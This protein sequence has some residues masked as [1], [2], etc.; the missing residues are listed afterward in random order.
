[1]WSAIIQTS[2]WLWTDWIVNQSTWTLARESAPPAGELI[3]NSY[4]GL[5]ERGVSV[6]D[7][8]CVIE[9][10][11]TVYWLR[12]LPVDQTENPVHF[13]WTVLWGVFGGPLSVW[14]GGSRRWDER[15]EKRRVPTDGVLQFDFEVK[16]FPGITVGGKTR[17]RFSTNTHEICGF[18]DVSAR[19]Y[20]LV[21]VCACCAKLIIKPF[22]KQR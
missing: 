13:V 5:F 14:D 22:P 6:D 21:V 2:R 4:H 17:S 20:H 16:H 10:G 8:M 12:V 11:P 15:K 3:E 18:P 7:S 9:A 19:Y 1:M